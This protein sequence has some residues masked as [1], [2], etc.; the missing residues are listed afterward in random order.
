MSI[1]LEANLPLRLLR[2]G[3]VR[4]IYDL[5]DKLLIVASDRISAF[6]FVLPCGIPD[7][8]K[9]LNQLSAFWFEKTAYIMPNH[10][11]KVIDSNI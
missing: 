7:K 6:D 5:G 3:K 10:L 9:V 11:V 8:G 4:D 1:L 2:R